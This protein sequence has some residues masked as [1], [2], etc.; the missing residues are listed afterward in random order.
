[1]QGDLIALVG[2]S[3]VGKTTAAEHLQALL[4][5]PYL[6]VG[7]DHFLNMFP[8][9]WDGQPAGPGVGMWYED[10]VDASGSPRSRIRYGAA[11]AKLLDGMR[12]AVCALLDTGNSVVLDEMPLDE[13]ILPAWRERLEGY[14]VFWVHL[15]ARLAVVE[16]REA[17]RTR[18]QKIGNARGHQLITEGMASD[19]ELD[20]SELTPRETAAA[21]LRA[22]EGSGP[23]DHRL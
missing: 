19:F 1:M 6:V 9:R 16:A 4:P 11:G 23:D 3:S 21:I 17:A 13:T 10:T 15:H 14:R 7:I 5:R 2:T 8:Q 20:V 22:W 18:G 12:A